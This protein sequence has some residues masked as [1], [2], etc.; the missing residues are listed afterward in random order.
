MVDAAPGDED[1]TRAVV[2]LSD[3]QAT[4][5]TLK[6]DDLIDVRCRDERQCKWTG[7]LNST[8]TNAAGEGVPKRSVTGSGLKIPTQHP[9][10]IFFVGFGD[11][12]INVGR[13]MAQATS[14]EYIGSTAEDLAS[15][16]EALGPYF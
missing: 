9:V 11:A 15:V 10:Q 7:S 12:D 6:L 1:S 14:G 3:G 16:I 13:L 2:V 5:G 8:P 4:T